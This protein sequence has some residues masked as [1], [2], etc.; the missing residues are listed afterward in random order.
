MPYDGLSCEF[1]ML[2][3]QF[4]TEP[5][6]FLS[7][8]LLTCRV[9]GFAPGKYR[10]SVSYNGAVFILSDY[11]ME[12]HA[13]IKKLGLEPSGGKVDGGTRVVAKGNNCSILLRHC[14]NSGTL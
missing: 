3:K 10:V 6:S 12:V 5:A 1:E 11:S 2:H 8:N 7:S 13:P 4:I 14:A 9:H